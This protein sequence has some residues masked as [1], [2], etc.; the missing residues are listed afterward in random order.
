[1]RGI[2]LSAFLVT[3]VVLTAQTTFC[4]NESLIKE[5][6]DSSWICRLGNRWLRCQGVKA[7]SLFGSVSLEGFASNKAA[8]RS[9]WNVSNI[10]ISMQHIL[11]LY[12]MALVCQDCL[13]SFGT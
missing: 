2:N 4:V 5:Y 7:M 6:F 9:P 11:V 3:I 8:A 10:N 1:M 12:E 13:H